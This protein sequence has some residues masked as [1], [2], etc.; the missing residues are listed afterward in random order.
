VRWRIEQVTAILALKFRFAGVQGIAMV[1][2]KKR[3][4]TKSKGRRIRAATRKKTAQ[5][6]VAKPTKNSTEKR[7]AKTRRSGVQKRVQ[8]HRQKSGATPV[9]EETVIDVVEEPLPG[10]VRITEIE[11]TNVTLSDTDGEE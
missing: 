11:E 9:V 3:A 2:R 5:R 4:T 1:S 6:V 8:E 7:T 10:V